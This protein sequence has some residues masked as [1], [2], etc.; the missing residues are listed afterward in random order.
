MSLLDAENRVTDLGDEPLQTQHSNP[1]SFNRTTPSSST[2]GATAA[3]ERRLEEMQAQLDQVNTEL[4]ARNLEAQAAQVRA[5]MPIRSAPA[6]APPAEPKP[7]SL[8]P[9]TLPKYKGQSEGEHIRWFR[10]AGIE[11]LRCP[12]YFP[13]EEAKILWA[14]PSL[15]GDPQIQWFQHTNEGSELAGTTF[16]DF[17]QFLLNLVSDPVNRR[18]LAYERFESARQLPNQKVSVFKAYLEETE[19]H[20][21]EFTEAHRANLFLAKLNAE[22]KSKILSTG[23]AA[24]TREG[25]LAKAIMQEKTLERVRSGGGNT[26]THSK[27]SKSS[28]NK[29]KGFSNKSNDQSNSQSSS[30]RGTGANDQREVR[31]STKRKRERDETARLKDVTCYGC[32]EKGHYKSDCPNPQK[33]TVGAVKAE[34]PKKEQAPPAPRKRSKKDQ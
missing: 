1:P 11:I 32:N 30:R 33:W 4:A 5:G 2:T 31:D 9:N 18:L 27:P 8:R 19:S 15:D 17:K 12:D 25:I 22:L 21:P 6:V 28:P 23:E 16:E 7:K 26:S 20:L 13:T 3:M 24:S 14:M 34:E 10:E 29:S